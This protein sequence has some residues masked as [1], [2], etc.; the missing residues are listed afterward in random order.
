MKTGNAPLRFIKRP[1]SLVLIGVFMLVAAAVAVPLYSVRSSSLPHGSASI[2]GPRSSQIASHSELESM[3]RGS[4]SPFARSILPVPQSSPEEISTFASDCTTSKSSFILGETVCAK[5]VFV[6]ETDRFVNWIDPNSNIAYGGPTTTPITNNT[7]QDFRYTPTIVGAWK[8]TIAD[9]SDSSIVPANFTVV[10]P[11][12]LATYDSTCTI[13]RTTFLLGETVCAKSTGITP[14]FARRFTWSDPAGFIRQTDSLTTDPQ[15]DL[16]TLPSSQTSMEGNTTVDNRGGWK[17]N[18]ISSRGSTLASAPFFVSA[19]TPSADLSIIKGVGSSSVRSG[20]HVSFILSVS[21]SGPNDAVNVTVTDATPANATFFSAMQTSGPT[22]AFSCTGNSTVTC[23]VAALAAG[24]RAILE[25]VYT[26]GT[27]GSTITNTATVSSDTTEVNSSDN[28][29]T[30]Q[31]TV[32]GSG[33]GTCTLTCPGDITTPANTKE[34]PNDPNSRDGAVVHFTPPSGQG[35]C[36]N[37]TTDHCN[38]CFFPVGTTT[39]TATADSGDACNFDVTV[40][41][42]GAPAISCPAD[43]TANADNDCQATVAVGTS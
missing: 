6:T 19:A 37:I 39:V 36:G 25:F 33:G 23:T 24:D 13:S 14:G 11:P 40:T 41:Q 31:V 30:A 3:V 18:V 35:T 1:Q 9:P 27:P 7:A 34:D 28:S 17:V 38:D 32:Q 12:P 5:T 22:P 2:I 4:R 21:N 26:A 43:E 8:V 15:T 16:F 42:A 29:S 10:P 20:D